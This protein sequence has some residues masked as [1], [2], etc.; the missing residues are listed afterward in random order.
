MEKQPKVLND[1]NLNCSQ[2]SI[3]TI[4]EIPY[5]FKNVEY[6]NLSRNMIASLSGIEQFKKTKIID[7]SN[8]SV[9]NIYYKRKFYILCQD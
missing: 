4:D 3:K 5:V 6:L 2:K 7:L 9:I 1:K 8:N